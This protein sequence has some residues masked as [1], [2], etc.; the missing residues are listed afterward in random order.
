MIACIFLSFLGDCRQLFLFSKNLG[1]SPLKG[2]KS[3]VVRIIC[4]CPVPHC[5]YLVANWYFPSS[6][7]TFEH[8]IYLTWQHYTDVARSLSINTQLTLG[9]QHFIAGLLNRTS[10]SSENPCWLLEYSS[11]MCLTNCL[12]GI[13]SISS[14]ERK[15]YSELLFVSYIKL[16][17]QTQERKSSLNIA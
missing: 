2:T 12:T 13:A 14:V 7:D 10:K 6:S 1:G 4:K 11:L 9:K 5:S 8:C 16:Q 15:R 3:V 17:L